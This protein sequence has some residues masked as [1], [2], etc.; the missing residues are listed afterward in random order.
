MIELAEILAARARIADVAVR[1]P[2]IEL[3]VDEA[4]AEIYCKL[5][6]MQP[7]N[8]FKIRGAANAIRSAPADAR[9]AG[10]LT[11]S[12]GNMA[13]GV[14]WVAREL[15]L[16]A[17]IAVPNTPRK[18]KPPRS[19]ASAAGCCAFPMTSGGSRSSPAGSRGWMGCSSTRSPTRR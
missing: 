3:R 17:T 4:P 1:T 16:E 6:T 10:L 5:E 8:S 11:A 19:N 12:A 18:Q 13:L 9:A 2:L 7:I 14:A 15:G